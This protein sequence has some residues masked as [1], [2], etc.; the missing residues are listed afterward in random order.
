ME[1]EN[2]T[3]EENSFVEN[4]ENIS[5]EKK[6]RGRPRKEV[7]EVVVKEKKPRSE[8]Q[9]EALKLAQQKR[10]EKL[11]QKKVEMVSIPKEDVPE[12]PPKKMARK[13]KE[14]EPEP[15]SEEEI[16]EIIIKKQKSKKPRKKI[17]VVEESDDEDEDEIIVPKNFKTQR[18]KK[19]VIK[20]KPPVNYF[21]D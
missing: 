5:L 12:L 14:P 8:K 20:V 9:L 21:C 3:I 19:S 16:E 4:Q 6:K 10:K 7:G 2:N 17:I 11:E 18:N 15:E 1:E 13:K